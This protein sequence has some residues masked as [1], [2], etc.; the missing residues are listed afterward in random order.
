MRIFNFPAVGAGLTAVLAAVVKTRMIALRPPA[1]GMVCGA[2]RQ[3]RR[4]E[5]KGEGED[6]AG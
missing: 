3:G 4:G 6:E 2:L 1:R 5:R